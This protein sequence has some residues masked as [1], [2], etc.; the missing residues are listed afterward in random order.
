MSHQPVEIP[1]P[2]VGPKTYAEDF[3]SGGDV[4][5]LQNVA[6]D[7]HRIGANDQSEAMISMPEHE[8]IRSQEEIPH[9]DEVELGDAQPSPNVGAGK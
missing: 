9:V 1:D 8:V 2:W 3:Y 7:P 6:L 5:P 4:R